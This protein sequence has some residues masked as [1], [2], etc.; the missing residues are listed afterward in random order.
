MT[1][2]LQ[3]AEMLR[4]YYFFHHPDRPTVGILRLDTEN[5]QHFVMV[6]KKGLQKLAQACLKHADDLKEIQ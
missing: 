3:K 1:L 5:E 4:G 6:T 2:E